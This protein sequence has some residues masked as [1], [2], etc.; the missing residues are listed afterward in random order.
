MVVDEMLVSGLQLML[1]GMGV[2]SF[3]LCILI[4]VVLIM[5]RLA[6]L[7]EGN[8][9]SERGKNRSSPVSQSVSTERVS[10]QIMSV[11]TAAIYR[12]RKNNS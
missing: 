7:I 10:P 3:F 12:Y 9:E 4:L 8:S 5:S 1:L 6:K 2:V 11:I